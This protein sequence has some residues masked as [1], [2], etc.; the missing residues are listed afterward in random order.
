MKN[1]ELKKIAAA[2]AAVNLV[3]E[4]EKLKEAFEKASETKKVDVIPPKKELLLKEIHGY[5][6]AWSQAG[7]MQSMSIRNLWQL[8]L[9]K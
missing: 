6:T 1:K 7:R 5:S 3:L 4:G 9:Y 2:V 8:K